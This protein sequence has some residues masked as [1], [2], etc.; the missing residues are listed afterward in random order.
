MRRRKTLNIDK[1]SF[2]FLMER[3]DKKYSYDEYTLLKEE[4]L[5]LVEG[6][7]FTAILDAI[8]NARKLDIDDLKKSLNLTEVEVKTLLKEVEDLFTSPL[9]NLETIKKFR[10]PLQ[11][12]HIEKLIKMVSPGNSYKAIGGME[13]MLDLMDSYRL[14]E[15][16]GSSS[17]SIFSNFLELNPHLTIG[18]MQKIMR[19]LVEDIDLK[20]MMVKGGNIGD[21]KV[22]DIGGI[23]FKLDKTTI[24]NVIISKLGRDINQFDEIQRIKIKKS[25]DWL[26]RQ[27]GSNTLFNPKNI[28]MSK[29]T[30]NAIGP[31][32]IVIFTK[33]GEIRVM[34]VVDEAGNK[35]PIEQ[36]ELDALNK[37]GDIVVKGDT[38]IGKNFFDWSKSAFKWYWNKFLEVDVR[39]KMETISVQGSKVKDRK[40]T[41]SFYWGLYA[42]GIKVVLPF[43]TS[44]II[45]K[46]VLG[47]GI[48]DK[49][50][51]PRTLS[52]GEVVD[53]NW[54]D[55]ALGVSD[56]G[57]GGFGDGRKPPGM[58]NGIWSIFGSWG[59]VGIETWNVVSSI[60]GWCIACDEKKGIRASIETLKKDTF[61]VIF[62]DLSLKELLD[63]KCDDEVWKKGKNNFISGDVFGWFTAWQ[64]K[65]SQSR[66]GWVLPEMDENKL[67][68]ILDKYALSKEWVEKNWSEHNPSDS[69][70]WDDSMK[71]GSALKAWF[72]MECGKMRDK[73]I[74]AK[75]LAMDNNKCSELK[76]YISIYTNDE[77]DTTLEELRSYFDRI[78]ITITTGEN[79]FTNKKWC[80]SNTPTVQ[81]QLDL[82]GYGLECGEEY[83]LSVNCHTLLKG[84]KIGEQGGCDAGYIVTYKTD[85]TGSPIADC[86]CVEKP[87]GR[88]TLEKEDDINVKVEFKTDC[89]YNFCNFF[90]GGGNTSWDVFWENLKGIGA[91]EKLDDESYTKWLL[92]PG[93]KKYDLMKFDSKSEAKKWLVDLPVEERNSVM[94]NLKYIPLY[95]L[96]EKFIE[97]IGNASNIPLENQWCSNTSTRKECIS[98]IKRW[99]KEKYKKSF[100]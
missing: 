66:I 17:R 77:C 68:E 74:A 73:M 39:K 24:D 35:I 57:F 75:L 56:T 29:L 65:A 5:L 63:K 100:V 23:P 31:D 61:D 60:T 90:S 8:K 54:L 89:N 71:K 1:K 33:K 14:T 45:W 48:D 10:D 59:K 78:G 7:R 34:N 42:K 64:Y 16:L 95:Q 53:Y 32:D 58:E 93:N 3:M 6:L 41:I 70:Y 67:L 50:W 40:G 15:I 99:V 69:P 47:I 20:N 55:C 96:T 2:N 36:S 52:S 62:K 87:E 85:A 51:E 49:Y 86:E 83:D 27:K 37:S 81:S 84:G 11:R 46:C 30:K 25:K 9:D 26:G 82:I 79:D 21:Y 91:E 94:K 97:D 76:E 98:E 18:E 92:I 88:I 12:A 80:K 13:N 43:T 22:I 38:N 4:K 28:E 72:I 19:N 44:K